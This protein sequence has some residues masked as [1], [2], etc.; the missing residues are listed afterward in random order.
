VSP[1]DLSF[2]FKLPL[3]GA[4]LILLTAFAVSASSM[5]QAWDELKE[6]QAID[7]D[8]LSHS[9]V[10]IVFPLMLHD[11]V[12]RVYETIRNPV[13]NT[14]PGNLTKFDSI[15][16]IDR[17]LKVFASSHPLAAPIQTE[18]ARIGPDYPWLAARMAKLGKDETLALEPPDSKLMYFLTPVTQGEATL[19]TLVMV[20]NREAFMPRFSEIAWHVGATGGVVLAILLPFNWYWGR[21]MARPLVELTKRMG[22][23]GKAMPDALDPRMY[24]HRDELGKLFDAYNQMLEELR[25][26]T[27]LEHQMI[28]SERLAALGQLAAGVA[29]EINNPLGGMLTA[30]DTLKCHTEMEPRVAKT[31]ALIERGLLQIKDTVGALLVEARLKSRNLVA[32]DIEDIRTLAA[33]PVKKKALHLDWDNRLV[34]DIALPASLI[35]QILMNLMLNAIHAAAQGGLV[36]MEIGCEGDGQGELRLVVRNDGKLLDDDEIAHLFE[37]FS[38]LSEGGHGLGLWV[39]YQIVHQLGGKISAKR[40]DGQMRFSVRIPLGESA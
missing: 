7:A 35:R 26:K 20:S 1:L 18:F 15:L 12:W 6:D 3:W 17:D 28:Q 24:G 34:E 25:E 9:L 10:A 40:K 30:I 23:I 31:I 13:Q 2:R 39:T 11:N 27:E 22:K 21:R 16:V 33:T 32:H 29:H 14:R 8:V 37:P 38:P 5:I 36:A 19:G 4:V